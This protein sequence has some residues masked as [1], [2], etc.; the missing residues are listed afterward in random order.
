MTAL[1]RPSGRTKRCARSGWRFE[2]THP[3]SGFAA[4]PSL[5]LREGDDILAAGRWGRPGPCLMSLT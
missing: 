3:L 4:S 1:P 5:T 2:L